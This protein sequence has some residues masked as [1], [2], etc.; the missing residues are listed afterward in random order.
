M[1]KV[2]IHIVVDFKDDNV[3]PWAARLQ[4]GN[5][6]RVI[7][8]K[9]KAKSEN[10]LKAYAIKSALKELKKKCSIEVFC[11][12]GGFRDMVLSKD[13][14]K[15]LTEILKPISQIYYLPDD[16]L[17]PVMLDLQ[18]SLEPDVEG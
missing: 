2:T 16:D 17:P 10:G 18:K 15:E 12:A 14:P 5:V 9:C 7:G 1:K 13:A 8:G 6:S 11:A 4:Y 3:S